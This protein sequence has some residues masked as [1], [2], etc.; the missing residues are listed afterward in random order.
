MALEQVAAKN[1][2][3]GGKRGTLV[4][5]TSSVINGYVS[6]GAD[7]HYTVPEVVEEAKSL[8]A[9]STIQVSVDLGHLQVWEAS[10]ESIRKVSDKLREVGGELSKTDIRVIALARD[11]CLAARGDPVIVTDDYALQNLADLMGLRFNSFAT[12]G[13]KRVYKWR[14]ECPGCG[15]RS[16]SR[17]EVCPVCGTRLRRVIEA[18]APR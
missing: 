3:I 8:V 11:L 4:L 17:A 10:E 1:R 9:A 18:G 13:I 16:G 15:R 7:D 2:G 12:R 5:D 6:R 14:K